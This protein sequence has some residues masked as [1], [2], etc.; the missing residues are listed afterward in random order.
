LFHKAEQ[1]KAEA[2]RI[3]KE[4]NDHDPK[5]MCPFPTK[6]YG[7]AM[8]DVNYGVD[9]KGSE[10]HG[11]VAWTE[12]DFVNCFKN[13]RDANTSEHSV[14]CVFHHHRQSEV[15]ISSWMVVYG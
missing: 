15:G 13:F 9:K 5:F 2:A 12:E 14:V 7:F 6:N 10:S 11:D 1:L 3:E 8:A 4:L